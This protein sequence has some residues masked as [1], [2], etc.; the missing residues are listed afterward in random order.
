MVIYYSKVHP[1]N[2]PNYYVAACIQIK[3]VVYVW[4]YYTLY[5]MCVITAE[6]DAVREQ[7]AEVDAIWVQ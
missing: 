4:A 5:C 3:S 7:Q 6:E 1:P 2:K